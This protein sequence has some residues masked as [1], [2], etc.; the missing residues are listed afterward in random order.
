MLSPK[1]KLPDMSEM[2][3]SKLGGGGSSGSSGSTARASGK[4]SG[5]PKAIKKR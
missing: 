2:L 1:Q 4:P 3:T 5:K